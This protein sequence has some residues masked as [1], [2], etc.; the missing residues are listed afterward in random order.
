MSAKNLFLITAMAAY[1]GSASAQSDSNQALLSDNDSIVNS[2]TTQD[3]QPLA[4]TYLD[5]V[6]KDPEWSGNWFLSVNG[7]MNAF[8]GKPVGCGDF[9]D[10]IKPLLNIS[11]GK[12]FTPYV[13]GRIS[14]QGLKMK[15]SNLKS[16]AFQS[17]HTDF[18]YNVSTHLRQDVEYLANW[19]CIPYVGVGIIRNSGAYH[20]PFGFSYGLIG[21]Y[22]IANR[23]HLVGEI[24]G[25]TTFRDFDG[26]GESDKFGDKLLHA[27][28][29]LSVTFGKNGWKRVIDAKPYIY[30]NDQLVNGINVFRE[31][32]EKLSKALNYDEIALTEMRKILEIEGL[33]G[34]YDLL[35]NC[36][37]EGKLHPK[38]NYSGLN[39]LRERLRNRNWNGDMENYKPMLAQEGDSLSANIEAYLNEIREGKTHIGAPVFF[40]F[41][42]KT[43]QLTDNSQITNIK[44]IAKVMKKY[45]LRAKII[46]AADSA[47]GSEST[48]NKLSDNR[49]TFIANQLKKYGVNEDMIDTKH[50]GGIDTYKP[51]EVNRHACVLLYAK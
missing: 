41:K 34:K 22:R 45:N 18:L 49:S 6:Y 31:Q 37:T 25:T 30:Q 12:W 17:V 8:V 44:E 19:D 43:S 2:F 42:I 26:I 1:I 11:V 47:T 4:P 36:E 21:R 38:N 51:N 3:L 39:S 5:G 35:S 24:G 32:N 7:G 28:L 46:G 48:N 10:R 9:G 29:G 50:C 16:H 33:I 13:G 23:V 20:K 40:F 14:Y 15:D 27:S